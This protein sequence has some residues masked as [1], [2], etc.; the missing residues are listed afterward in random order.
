[1]WWIIANAVR[2]HKRRVQQGRIKVL[3]DI[4]GRALRSNAYEVCWIEN[5]YLVLRDDR[6]T[7]VK[8]SSTFTSCDLMNIAKHAPDVKVKSYGPMFPDMIDCVIPATRYDPDW[9]TALMV[10]LVCMLAMMFVFISVLG[11]VAHLLEKVTE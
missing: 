10:I 11:Y 4:M 8:K 5:E 2:T 1:M 9:T 6:C 3:D 7:I